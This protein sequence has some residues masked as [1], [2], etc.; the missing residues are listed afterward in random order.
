MMANLYEPFSIK[1]QKLIFM[2]P[3]EAELTKLFSNTF[4][5]SKIAL[6]NEFAEVCSAFGADIMRVRNGVCSDRRIGWEFMYPSSGYGGSCFPKD[7]KGLVFAVK[8]KNLAP[9]IISS[10]DISNSE[11]KSFLAREFGAYFSDKGGLN[12]KVFAVWGLTFKPKTD[13]VRESAAIDIINFLLQN[14]AKVKA[15][16]PKGIENAKKI[17]GDRIEYFDSKYDTLKGADALV[18]LTEWPVYRSPDFEEIKSLLKFPVIFDGRNIFDPERLN[19]LGFDYVGIGR[20]Y[21]R[22]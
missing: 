12:G 11:H 17:F 9:K 21:L 1:K 5:A 2:K 8:Q 19:Q 14:G 10:I 20:K 7:I 16:D 15:N 3:V 13:D 4:L 6:I 18:L 22:K